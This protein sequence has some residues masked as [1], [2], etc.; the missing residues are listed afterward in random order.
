MKTILPIRNKQAVREF[1]NF[2]N[3]VYCEAGGNF[4]PIAANTNGMM[5]YMELLGYEGDVD[6]LIKDMITQYQKTPLFERQGKMRSIGYCCTPAFAAVYKLQNEMIMV[7][8]TAP[9]PILV[10][11]FPVH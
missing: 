3:K 4:G 2:T 5:E 7:P 10:D 6:E 1:I 8:V 9:D 11:N